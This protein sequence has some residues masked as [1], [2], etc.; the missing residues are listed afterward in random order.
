M[1]FFHPNMPNYIRRYSLGGRQFALPGLSAPARP[2]EAPD[3]LSNTPI[4]SAWSFCHPAPSVLFLAADLH[5]T[6][7]TAEFRKAP[8]RALPV[9]S[10]HRPANVCFRSAM[11]AA[12]DK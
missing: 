3:H 12:Q 4:S 7:F 8:L 10:I 9:S 5:K 1:A 2:W 6:R 11:E